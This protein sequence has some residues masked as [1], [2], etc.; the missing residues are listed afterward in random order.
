MLA[1]LGGTCEINLHSS[2]FHLGLKSVGISAKIMLHPAL[3]SLGVM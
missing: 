1:D 3:L 2:T